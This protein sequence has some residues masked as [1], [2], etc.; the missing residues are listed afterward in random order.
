MAVAIA[1]STVLFALATPAA[2]ASPGLPLDPCTLP[3]HAEPVRCGRLS[4]PEDR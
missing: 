4:V 3:G 2:A 1:L